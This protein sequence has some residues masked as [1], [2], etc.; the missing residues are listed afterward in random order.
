MNLRSIFAAALALAVCGCAQGPRDSFARLPDGRRIHLVCSGAGSPVVVFESGF[1]A[2]ASAWSK[3]QPMLA[4]TTKVCAYDRA[5]YGRSD[6]GP[7]PR[8][9]AAIASDLDRALRAAN[10]KGPFVMVGHSAGGLYVQL[11]ADRR[12]RDVA[13]MVLVDPSV[14]YQDRALSMFG[15]GAGSLAGIRSGVQRCLVLARGW[16]QTPDAR[17]RARCY[18]DGGKMGPTSLWVTQLSELDTLWGATSDEVAAGPSYGDMP[19]VVLTAGDT[20][21]GVP[22]GLR[23]RVDARWRELHQ[24]IARRS[25]RGQ[26]RLVPDSGH[27]IMIDRPE[28]VIEAV[29]AVVAK[30]RAGRR[31]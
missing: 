6:P 25:S 13:G 22:V 2:T 17:E 3:V 9:G 14:E 29:L 23:S 27:L 21:K 31:P 10:I 12:P 19:I 7:M 4:K 26:E 16:D 11:F 5:G 30:A 18:V 28:A 20:N 24:M 15:P 8:D 1:G